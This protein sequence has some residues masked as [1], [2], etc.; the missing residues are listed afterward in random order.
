MNAICTSADGKQ[1]ALI[2]TSIFNLR[3]KARRL[4]AVTLEVFP[5]DEF[6]ESKVIRL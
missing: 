3:I 4:H 1:R 6:L 2:G 5:R